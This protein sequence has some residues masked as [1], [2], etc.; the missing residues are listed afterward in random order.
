[1][2]AP[3]SIRPSAVFSVA[4][5]TLRFSLC[6]QGVRARVPCSGSAVSLSLGGAQEAQETDLEQLARENGT[7]RW[8]RGKIRP[9]WCV[10]PESLGAHR[11]RVQSVEDAQEMARHRAAGVA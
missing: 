2:A 5:V 8:S 6:L 9:S 7:G 11:G 1:M 4:H 10:P 3:C